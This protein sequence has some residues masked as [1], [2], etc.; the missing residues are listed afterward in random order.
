VGVLEVCSLRKHY[1]KVEALKGLSLR[2][3]PGERAVL[4][5]PNG[6]GKTTTLEIL[7]G[8]L[9]P[10]AGWA[11]VFGVAKEG[12]LAGPPLPVHGGS[13]GRLPAAAA[14]ASSG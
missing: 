13:L 12:A 1:G 10:S 6:S 14:A 8:F 4:L 9:R 2:L 7:G 11:R 5:G 3:E